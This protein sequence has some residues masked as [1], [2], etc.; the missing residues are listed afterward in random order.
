MHIPLTA[1]GRPL[2]S[3]RGF[4]T[5]ELMVVI[6]IVAILASIAVPSFSGIVERY[7][8]RRASEDLIASL[9]L[10]RSEAMRRGGNVTLRKLSSPECPAPSDWSCGWFA[11]ANG[12]GEFDASEQQIQASF[13][14]KGV[15]ATAGLPNPPT[16]L[17]LDRWGQFNGLSAL[18]FQLK[19][20]TAA[21]ADNSRTRILCLASGGRLQ[22]KEG[23][24][25]CA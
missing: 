11:D 8:V 22:V 18:N 21:D 14:P 16:R 9:Y 13:A 7:R 1:R 12:N 4:T 24:G 20:V 17:K 10:A 6:A 25:Q 2:A 3:S 15:K 19:P 23:V 5:I